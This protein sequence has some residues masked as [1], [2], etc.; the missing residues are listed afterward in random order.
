MKY[1]I[2]VERDHNECDDP[3]LVVAMPVGADPHDPDTWVDAIEPAVVD[4]F[5][6]DDWCED[7][8]NEDG[9]GP[10]RSR[11]VGSDYVSWSFG[12]WVDVT[13]FA[14]PVTDS[15]VFN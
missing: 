13:A 7:Y 5:E 11:M 8:E 12:G 10:S 14:V 4:H 9:D 6:P 2:F 1:V 3:R 15:V